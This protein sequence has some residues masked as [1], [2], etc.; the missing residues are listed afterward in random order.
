MSQSQPSEKEILECF[1]K[2]NLET[3]SCKEIFENMKK[4]RKNDSFWKFWI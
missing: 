2:Q 4:T 1:K 3:L